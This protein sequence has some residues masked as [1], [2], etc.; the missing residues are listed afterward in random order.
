MVKL[1]EGIILKIKKNC[2]RKKRKIPDT[3]L[4]DKEPPKMLIS[5]FPFGYLLLDMQPTLKGSLFPQ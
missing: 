2:K 3:T 5:S 4:C 1:R